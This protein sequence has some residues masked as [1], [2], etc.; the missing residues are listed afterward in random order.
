MAFPASLF[1][2][3]V[4]IEMMPSVPKQDSK[5]FDTALLLSDV[6]MFALQ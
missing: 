3:E 2:G 4:G 1:M 5:S 6:S